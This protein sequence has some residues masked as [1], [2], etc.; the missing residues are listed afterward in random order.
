MVWSS[1][2]YHV[3]DEKEE[4]NFDKVWEQET[5]IEKDFVCKVYYKQNEKSHMLAYATFGFLRDDTVEI[6]GLYKNDDLKDADLPK[7]VIKG[8]GA[9]ILVETLHK[10]KKRGAKYAILLPL[11][12]GSGKLL[13]YYY[14]FGFRCVGGD[15]VEDEE[16]L[17]S[18]FIASDRKDSKEQLAK[19][20]ENYTK[21]FIMRM[22][23]S[24]L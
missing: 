19:T 10:A 21:C 17:Y 16:I 22:D 2:C 15:R 7:H 9:K 1:R 6:K 18:D 14:K 13:Q 24:V 20:Q 3:K 5:I 12:D 8:A 11:D 23:L 4:D